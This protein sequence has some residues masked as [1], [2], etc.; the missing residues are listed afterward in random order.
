MKQA[1]SRGLTLKKVHRVIKFNQEAWMAKYISKNIDLRKKPNNDSERD[2]FKIMCNSV[3][4][5]TMQNFHKQRDIKLVTTDKRRYQLVSE[6]NYR[7][8][9]WFSES[10]LAIEMKNIKV[11]MDKPIYLSLSILDYSKTSSFGMIILNQNIM[12]M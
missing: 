11:K 2:F 8:A 9:K 10:L 5:K 1:L 7:T 12:I 6:P 4:G 3:F